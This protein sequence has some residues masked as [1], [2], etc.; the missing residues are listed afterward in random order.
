M[1]LQLTIDEVALLSV[2]F[3]ALLALYALEMLVINR[4][5]DLA[6][7]RYNALYDYLFP[8]KVRRKP[9]KRRRVKR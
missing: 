2:L 6:I 7:K 3:L 9:R 8:R 4:K 5:I 1:A